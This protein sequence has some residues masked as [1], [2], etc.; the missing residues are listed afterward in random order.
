MRAARCIAGLF[1]KRPMKLSILRLMVL[2]L[3]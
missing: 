3:G 1:A 2:S